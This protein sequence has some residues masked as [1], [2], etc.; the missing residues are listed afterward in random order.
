[1]ASSIVTLLGRL[2]EAPVPLSL[3][4]L[5]SVDMLGS[6][7]DALRSQHTWG[8]LGGFLTYTCELVVTDPGTQYLLAGLALH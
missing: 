3:D 2:H 6:Y 8:V 4:M 5:A 7:L 1:V